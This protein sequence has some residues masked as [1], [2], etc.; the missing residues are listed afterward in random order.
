MLKV[1]NARNAVKVM[2]ENY[3]HSLDSRSSVTVIAAEIKFML[4]TW[5]TMDSC[6]I[7]FI[8]DHIAL[9]GRYIHL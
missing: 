2:T 3:L 8:I 7:S 4:C 9:G 1:T 5:T 6:Y